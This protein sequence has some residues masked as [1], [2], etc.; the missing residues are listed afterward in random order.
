MAHFVE[1]PGF[2]IV[3]PIDCN[4]VIPIVSPIDCSPVIPVAWR[5]GVGDDVGS[6]CVELVEWAWNTSSDVYSKA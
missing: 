3:S 2:S 1:L 4:P 6:W 5:D